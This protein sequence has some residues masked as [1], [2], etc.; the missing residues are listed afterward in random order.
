MLPGE[1]IFKKKSFGGGKKK[2]NYFPLCN[3]I[4]LVRKACEAQMREVSVRENN[5]EKNTK[6]KEKN[7]TMLC[8][9]YHNL[10]F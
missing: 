10:N 5:K 4:I 6:L 2:M 1:P 3:K 8:V 7:K 9:F